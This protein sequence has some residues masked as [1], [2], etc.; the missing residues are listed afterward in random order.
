M[1]SHTNKHSLRR[2]KPLLGTIVEIEACGDSDLHVS[3]AIERAFVE[4][5]RIESKMNFYDPLSELSRLNRSGHTQNLIIDGEIYRILEIAKSLTSISGGVFDIC[6][7]NGSANDIKLKGSNCIYF[8]R[9]LKINLGG[10]AK[11][12]AVDRALECL[13]ENKIKHAIVNAGGDISA[14]GKPQAIH[15]RLPDQPQKLVK[16]MDL[17]D[18]AVATSANYFNSTK[19]QHD[20]PPGIVNPLNGQSWRAEQSVTVIAK[21]CIIADA[22]TKIV[23]LAPDCASQILENLDAQAIV[24]QMD[25]GHPRYK[26]ISGKVTNSRATAYFDYG[27]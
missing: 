26:L 4:V 18:G 10:I 17:V 23:A 9:P 21:T 24:V 5:L 19:K 7:G 27:H 3:Q 8:E 12:Y 22:L 14:Y 1:Q 6:V 13:S 25:E 16:L 20:G 15:V 11:G 2:A